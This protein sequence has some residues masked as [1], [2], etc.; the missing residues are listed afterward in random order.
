[1][2]IGFTSGTLKLIA[3]FS[4]DERVTE[5]LRILGLKVLL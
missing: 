3:I 2:K 5:S 1:M 4:K